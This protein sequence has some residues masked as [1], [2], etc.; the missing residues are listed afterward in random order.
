MA[1]VSEAG[2][3]GNKLNFELNLVPF[4]DLLSALVLFLLLS[5]VWVQMGALP[6]Q[7]E[8]PGKS[9]TVQ[10]ETSKLAVLLTGKGMQLTW[11]NSLGGPSSA[12]KLES[13]GKFLTKAVSEKKVT[14]AS[15]SG[16]D[17]VTY[18]QVVQMIDQL[19]DFGLTSVGL[20]TN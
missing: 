17:A 15:V 1:G 3:K 10:T 5:A 12:D 7:A 6:T 13:V 9:E 14:S 11:P 16:T 19:K 8:A 18:G 4:I 2:G 20:N